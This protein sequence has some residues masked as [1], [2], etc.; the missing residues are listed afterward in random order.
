M[1]NSFFDG[2]M[3][4]SVAPLNDNPQRRKIEALFSHVYEAS[5]LACAVTAAIL[6]QERVVSGAFSVSRN[7]DRDVTRSADL[8]RAVW[9]YRW[10]PLFNHGN[11]NAWSRAT[12]GRSGEGA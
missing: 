3:V 5:S 4:Q 10:A 11:A 12:K 2:S 8:R 7:T 1:G 6:S 9:A